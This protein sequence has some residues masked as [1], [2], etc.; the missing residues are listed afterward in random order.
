MIHW[1]GAGSATS[2]ER[3]A[4][5]YKW[6]VCVTLTSNLLFQSRFYVHHDTDL[7]DRV[8][9]RVRRGGR[10]GGRDTSDVTRWLTRARMRSER[11]SSNTCSRGGGEQ[12]QPCSLLLSLSLSL[13]T[14]TSL[15][16]ML[17]M[18]TSTSLSTT[19]ISRPTR[20]NFRIIEM[21]LFPLEIIF[22]DSYVT[23]TTYK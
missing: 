22:K 5:V 6:I 21:L 14:S 10:G 12:V 3:L 15:S 11:S 4:I 7:D 2:G 9:L 16:T 20:A 19:E 18:S 17:S 23:T 1:Q 8:D 13:S